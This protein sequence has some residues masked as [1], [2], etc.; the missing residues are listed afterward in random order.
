MGGDRMDHLRRLLYAALSSASERQLEWFL[1]SLTMFGDGNVFCPPDWFDV[2]ETSERIDQLKTERDDIEAAVADAEESLQRLRK[3]M[4][5]KS[6]RRREA[7]TSE[8]R[9]LEKHRRALKSEVAMLRDGLRVMA[10]FSTSPGEVPPPA[11]KAS[12]AAC[13]VPDAPGVYFV[14]LD[15]MLLYVGKS[16]SLNKRLRLR[17]HHVLREGMGLSWVLVTGAELRLRE[18]KEI[19]TQRPLLN[20]LSAD[21]V[22]ATLDSL[23]GCR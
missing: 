19:L 10:P 8:I 5:D 17:S 20:F 7:L 22:S 4:T 18:R 2:V 11:V 3:E 15:E 16:D 6:L 9:E 12:D 23:M 21:E 13:G 1:F 14:W